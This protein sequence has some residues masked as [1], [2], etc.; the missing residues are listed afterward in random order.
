MAVFFYPLLHELGHIVA[1]VLTRTKLYDFKLFP[2]YYVVF[3]NVTANEFEVCLVGVSGMI[4]PL[5]VSFIL[6]SNKFWIWLFSFY[7][8]GISMLAFGLSCVSILCYEHNIV[9]HNEDIIKVIE[10]SKM[11]IWFWY[12]MMLC[13]F[14]LSIILVVSSKPIKKIQLLF[15]I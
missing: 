11:K 2:A 15:E 7:L 8:K 9:W 4:L 12:T 13:F 14:V 10:L 1:I 6:S 3:D 5:I